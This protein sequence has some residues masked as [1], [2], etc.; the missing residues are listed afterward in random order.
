MTF[1]T[2]CV[3]P[4][5]PVYIAALAGGRRGGKAFFLLSGVAFSLGFIV[6][7]TLMGLAASKVGAILNGGR[8][9][10]MR[11]G[12]IVILLMG[13]KLLHFIEIPSLDRVFRFKG[14][15]SQQE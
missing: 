7:F 2:P 4:L 11:L 8:E 6:V 12:G 9:Y 15:G 3:L 10:L 14:G 1:F 13:L 5:I